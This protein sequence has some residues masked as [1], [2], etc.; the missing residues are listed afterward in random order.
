VIVQLQRNDLWRKPLCSFLKWCTDHNRTLDCSLLI[1]IQLSYPLPPHHAH[2]HPHTKKAKW[3]KQP[4]IPSHNPVTSQIKNFANKN[5]F[6]LKDEYYHSWKVHEIYKLTQEID[7]SFF[8]SPCKFSRLPY[9]PSHQT[10]I[11][12]LICHPNTDVLL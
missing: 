8:P 7:W 10:G 6:L 4:A 12:F 1:Y 9:S 3:L 2:T 5:T 11:S